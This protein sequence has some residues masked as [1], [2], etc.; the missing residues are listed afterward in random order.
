MPLCLDYDTFD[1]IFSVNANR[2]K[3]L[4]RKCVYGRREDG[5]RQRQSLQVGHEAVG[6]ETVDGSDLRG[7]GWFNCE[8]E[9]V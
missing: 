6:Q 2:G 7:G 1:R 5:V 8:K 4:K 9:K 3:K